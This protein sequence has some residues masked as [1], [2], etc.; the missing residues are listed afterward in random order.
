MKIGRICILAF[1]SLIALSCK[2]EAQNTDYHWVTRKNTI[3]Q[4]AKIERQEKGDTTI[5]SYFASSD[6]LNY[7]TVNSNL[8]FIDG[9]YQDGVLHQLVDTTIII[10]DKEYRVAKYIQNEEVIDGGVVHYYTPQFGVF[11]IHSNTWSGLQYLQSTDST[12]NKLIK[13]LI[14]A[15]VPEFYVRGELKSELEKLI[16]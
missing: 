1:T 15:T 5:L 9:S 3:N 8:L 11:A 13:R 4:I 7:F 10:S 2:K 16:N 14:K 12:K 6:T